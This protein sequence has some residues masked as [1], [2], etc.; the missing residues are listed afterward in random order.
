MTSGPT[1]PSPASGREHPR[2]LSVRDRLGALD[3]RVRRVPPV[4]DLLAVLDVYND[5]G[6]GLAAPGLA[7]SALFATI[8]ALLLVVSV[9]IVVVDDPAAQ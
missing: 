1:G 6:G 4:R 8:P 9:V 3:R 7:F 2:H 5:A